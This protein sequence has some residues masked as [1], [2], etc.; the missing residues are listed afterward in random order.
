MEAIITVRAEEIKVDANSSTSIPYSVALSTGHSLPYEVADMHRLSLGDPAN[1]NAEIVL[2]A[3]A[4]V[5][6]KLQINLTGADRITVYGGATY[7]AG[8]TAGD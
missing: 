2:D 6:E 3:M 4:K 8:T 5:G 1:I 7:Q